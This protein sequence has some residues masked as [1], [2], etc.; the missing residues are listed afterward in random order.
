MALQAHSTCT[1]KSGF[2]STSL[3]ERERV[4]QVLSKALENWNLSCTNLDSPDAV[5]SRA[6]PEDEEAF[7]CNLQVRLDRE[8]YRS[9]DSAS[10]SQRHIGM[11]YGRCHDSAIRGS[12]GYHKE[13]HAISDV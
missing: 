6:H 11:S 3:R 13:A 10:M 2:L 4:L 7:I 8:E 1:K 9:S 5:G 12:D